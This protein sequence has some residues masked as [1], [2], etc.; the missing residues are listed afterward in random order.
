MLAARVSIY[1][2]FVL[3]SASLRA[4]FKRTMHNQA[5]FIGYILYKLVEISTTKIRK[6]MPVKQRVGRTEKEE[7]VLSCIVDFLQLRGGG[8][9]SE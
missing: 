9:G 6:H 7:E 4:V 8:V 1:T 2:S 3:S 5:L